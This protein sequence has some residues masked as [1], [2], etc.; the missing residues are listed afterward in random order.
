MRVDASIVQEL[1][2]FSRYSTLLHDLNKAV[3]VGLMDLITDRAGKNSFTFVHDKVWEAAY[4]SMIST[5]NLVS[6]NLT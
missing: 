1:S 3:E 5:D 4:A 2:C 6:L